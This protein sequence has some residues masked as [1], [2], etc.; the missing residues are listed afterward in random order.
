MTVSYLADQADAIL[1][2]ALAG[3]AEATTGHAPPS[4]TI[5]T[6]GPPAG[7]VCDDGLLAV[8]LDTVTHLPLRGSQ[9]TDHSCLLVAEPV[10][11]V[12]LLRC[13]PG[14]ND[15][16]VDPLPNPDDLD[17]SAGELLVDLW[18]LLTE[19]YDRIA[20]NTLL[21]DLDDPCDITI[22]FARHI[23]PEGRTAGW[24]LRLTMSANDTGPSG[25]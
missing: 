14:L 2:A 19:L 1:A 18:A 3:L 24:E 21:P 22:D 8:Y 12:V 4:T 6:H 23:P 9:N 17:D 5:V 15:S 10:F 20:A 7:D 13:V 16:R 25:S 11:V